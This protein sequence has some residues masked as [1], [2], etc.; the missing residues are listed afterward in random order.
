VATGKESRKH[1]SG[2]QGAILGSVGVGIKDKEKIEVA[3][4][5]EQEFK[6]EGRSPYFAPREVDNHN[7]TGSVPFNTYEIAIFS[8]RD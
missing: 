6:C 3:V 7:E 4:N 2:G 1:V 8:T 5:D